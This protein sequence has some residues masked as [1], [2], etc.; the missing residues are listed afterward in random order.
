[1]SY[2]KCKGN[3]EAR[4]RMHGTIVDASGATQY[5]LSGSIMH[6]I[7]AT[8]NT[9]AAATAL[10][11]DVGTAVTVYER[12]A[13][14]PNVEAQFNLTRFAMSLNDELDAAHAAPTD[15]RL[16]PDVRCLEN[17]Q[18]ALATEEKL[19]LEEKQRDAAKER[20]TAG[21]VF[22][23]LWF[24]RCDGQDANAADNIVKGRLD[25]QHTW[26]YNGRYWPAREAQE[27]GGLPDIYSGGPAMSN[28]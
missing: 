13:D 6:S 23:P 25:S 2:T 14:V 16:R 11:A 19:R 10:Q 21:V 15:S 7:C 3:L 22:Q 8:A 24:T 17:A 27:W 4:G 28:S 5:E 20:V 1:M 18:Y 26:Q 12:P 9:P